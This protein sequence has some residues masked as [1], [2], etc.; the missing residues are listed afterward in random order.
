MGETSRILKSVSLL[1]WTPSK[2]VC[3]VERKE[4]GKGTRSGRGLCAKTTMIFNVYLPVGLALGLF[5]SFF[6]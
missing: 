3:D 1:V 4:S 2:E 6:F 5:H